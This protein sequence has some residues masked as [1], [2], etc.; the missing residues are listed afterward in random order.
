VQ[1]LTLEAEIFFAD[2]MLNQNDPDVFKDRMV[3]CQVSLLK[4][5]A[6]A[7]QQG[8]REVQCIV[9]FSDVVKSFI[10]EENVIAKPRKDQQVLNSGDEDFLSSSEQS[11]ESNSSEEKFEI[12]YKNSSDCDSLSVKQLI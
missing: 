9:P 11:S 6:V 7:K 2:A 4:A 10:P 5:Y 1:I 12:I 8:F 3:K